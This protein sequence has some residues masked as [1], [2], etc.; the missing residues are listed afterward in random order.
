MSA[1][2]D[3]C[4]EQRER[5]K[6][7]ENVEE[8]EKATLMKIDIC[9]CVCREREFVYTLRLWVISSRSPFV[10]N[11]IQELNRTSYC[12]VSFPMFEY[13]SVNVCFSSLSCNALT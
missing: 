13:L 10:S 2:F 7:T 6:P 1:I 8:Q 12:R 4:H 9:L 5:V 11:L 3:G